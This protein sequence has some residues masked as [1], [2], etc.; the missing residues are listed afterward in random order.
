MLALA[1]G[2]G[3]GRLA[4]DG[5]G[6]FIADLFERGDRHVVVLGAGD[7][8]RHEPVERQPEGIGGAKGADDGRRGEALWRLF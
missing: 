5:A 1:L 2:A 3:V 8:A 6:E 7:G 4:F